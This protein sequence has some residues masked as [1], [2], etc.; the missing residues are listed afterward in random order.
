MRIIT[1]ID[2][3]IKALLNFF[4]DVTNI[5]LTFINLGVDY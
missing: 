4:I 3:T 5:F 2:N 1:N